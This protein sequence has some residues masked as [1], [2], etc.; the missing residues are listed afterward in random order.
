MLVQ[1]IVGGIVSCTVTAKLHVALPAAAVAVQTT[2]FVPRRN[3]VPLGGAQITGTGPATFVA[4]T[5]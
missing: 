4:V 5:V 2:W 3:P 1:S